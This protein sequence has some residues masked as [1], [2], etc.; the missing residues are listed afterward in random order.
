MYL[1]KFQ[2]DGKQV[3]QIASL[4]NNHFYGMMASYQKSPVVIAGE[5]NLEG[6]FYK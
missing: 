6:Q 4:K 2:F 3:T 5:S 1:T